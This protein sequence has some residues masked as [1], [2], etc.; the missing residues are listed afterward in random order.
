M[1]RAPLKNVCHCTPPISPAP[2]D[3]ALNATPLTLIILFPF[4]HIFTSP[5]L[6]PRS[7]SFTRFSYS[8][9]TPFVNLNDPRRTEFP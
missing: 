6:P 7:F 8:R 1:E 2:C 9:R 5:F 4:A 3:C